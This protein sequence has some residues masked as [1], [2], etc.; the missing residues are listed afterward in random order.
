MYG[1]LVLAVIV[2]MVQKWCSI[3]SSVWLFYM[4]YSTQWSGQWIHF[5]EICPTCIKI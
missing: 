5:I 1:S 2:A 3:L 4:L